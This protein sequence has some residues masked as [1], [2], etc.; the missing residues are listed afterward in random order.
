MYAWLQEIQSVNTVQITSQQKE[1]KS[2]LIGAG[3]LIF[4]TIQLLLDASYNS[5]NI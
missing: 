5:N 2:R 3:R 4:A 1:T